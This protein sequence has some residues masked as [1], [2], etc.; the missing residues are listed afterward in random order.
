MY[1]FNAYSRSSLKA[2]NA[3]ASS[4]EEGLS[5]KRSL[6][7]RR[8]HDLLKFAP[9]WP[10]TTAIIINHQK[11]VTAHSSML[12]ST[13]RR[14]VSSLLTD[15]AAPNQGSFSSGCSTHIRYL[16]SS[17]KISS[18]EDSSNRRS[19]WEEQHHL[20]RA[21]SRYHIDSAQRRQWQKQLQPH[22]RRSWNMMH[23]FHDNDFEDDDV[24]YSSP[25]P[26]EFEALQ[27]IHETSFASNVLLEIRDA[28]V[29]AS[30]HHPSFT[31]LARH[32]LHLVCYTHADLVDA[33]TRNRIERWTVQGFPGAHC[34]FVDS[35]VNRPLMEAA[36]GIDQDSKE[37]QLQPNERPYDFLYQQLLHHL[38]QAGGRNTALT[39][40][41]ANTGKS[42]VL[43]ALLR[44][45]RERG[46]RGRSLRVLVQNNNSNSNK[47]RGRTTTTAPAPG[48]CDRPGVT[49]EITEYVLR[50][51]PR[52]YWMDV[53]GVTPPIFYFDER[54]EAWFALAAANLLA[55]PYELLVDVNCQTALCDYVLYCMNRDGNFGYVQRANLEGPTEDILEVL[56]AVKRGYGLNLPPDELRLAQCKTFLKLF[57]SGSFGSVVLDDLSKPFQKFVF[58]ASHFRRNDERQRKSKKQYDNDFHRDSNGGRELFDEDVFSDDDFEYKL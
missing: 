22:R 18:N 4:R 55:L 6:G 26:Y 10:T 28:R 57:N 20:A 41:V 31:R 48:I 25:P 21:V 36:N 40:G 53:P 51:K 35:R 13:R 2:V 11:S 14:I 7:Y 56:P 49:R 39:V 15:R 1:V 52:A 58:N 38:D 37:Q 19:T 12:T 34:Y 32:R 3:L 17:T 44:T 5:F 29:P 47:K 46:E 8:Q 33:A 45:A 24:S 43:M 54:P 16:S 23:F 50:D 42:S 30:S 27:Q 9:G